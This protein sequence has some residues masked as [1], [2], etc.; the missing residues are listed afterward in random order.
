MRVVS[1]TLW[2][3]ALIACAVGT[4]FA[5][6]AKVCPDPAR[7]CRGFKAHDLSFPLTD[8]ARARAEQRSEPFFAVILA[9]A[10][11]MLS[12]VKATGRFPGANVRRMQVVFVHP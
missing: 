12:V 1:T 7:P 3:V 9:T 6:P 2:V 11:R 10:E 8:D 5:G 4:A